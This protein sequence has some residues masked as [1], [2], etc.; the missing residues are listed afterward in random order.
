[1]DTPSSSGSS[2]S[3]TYTGDSSTDNIGD[4]D[5]EETPALLAAQRHA[6]L[7]WY[8]RQVLVPWKALVVVGFVLTLV[9]LSIGLGGLGFS[10]KLS[11][12]VLPSPAVTE[13]Y[14]AYENFQQNNPVF[15]NGDTEAVLMLRTNNVSYVFDPSLDAI[16]ASAQEVGQAVIRAVDDAAQALWNGEAPAV[17]YTLTWYYTYSE[18]AH[19]Q[20]LAYQFVYPN[21]TALL[22]AVQFDD[23]SAVPDSFLTA[24]SAAV[25]AVQA[26][27]TEEATGWQL[28][29]TGAS[30]RWR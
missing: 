12:N 24:F 11:N 28:T 27:Y 19:L 7:H 2:A 21:F 20:N 14:A 15:V 13:V 5:F 6:G 10:A 8:V 1:M 18:S 29:A 9:V 30:L 16:N 3:S 23:A 17:A 22:I 26:N 4:G 25:E